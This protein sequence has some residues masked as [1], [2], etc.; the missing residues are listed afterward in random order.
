MLLTRL[1]E[2]AREDPTVPVPFYAPKAVR[3]VIELHPDGSL[4]S[5]QLTGLADQSNRD[6]RNGVV[7]LVPSVQ[8]SGTAA[9]PMLA[10]D[11]AEYVLGWATDEA[12][13]AKAVQYRAAFR[14]LTRRWYEAEK[15]PEAEALLAFLE[16]PHVAALARPEDLA[17]NHLVAVRVAGVFAHETDSAE[18]FWAAEAGS[19]KGSDRTG[20]CLVCGQAGPLLQTIPQQVPA[21]LV[22]GATNSA[23]LVSLNKPVHGFALEPQLVHTPIC[24][25]CGLSAMSALEAVLRGESAVTLPG[26]DSRLAWWVTGGAAFSL[27]ALDDPS[28][29]NVADLLGSVAT[30]RKPGEV[31]MSF[32]CALTVGGNVARIMVRDW[33]EL[34]LIEIQENIGRWFAEHQIADSWT[35]QPRYLPFRRLVNATGRWIPGRGKS[36]GTYAKF[37]APGADRPDGMERALWLAALLGKP[38]PPA[39]LA[40]VVHRIRTDGRLDTERAALVR[41]ALRRR[42]GLAD[43]E[44]YMPVL[45]PE[46]HRPSYLAGRL[47]A[48]LEDLQRSAGRARGDQDLNVTF[49]DRYY[50]RAITSPAVALV[51]GERDSRA[52]LKRLRRDRPAW[53]HTYE[54]QLDELYDELARAGGVPHGAVLPDQAAFILGYHQQH[55]ATRAARAAASSDKTPNAID[56]GDP[57]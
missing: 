3:W 40:H 9:Q 56:E 32:F 13:K 37:G 6:T 31:D 52:W 26:Q 53:A 1:V 11:T 50:A 57:A 23:S 24:V 12:R 16:A 47:F 27:D 33:I 29:Q 55:A 45:N 49:A 44:E 36:S 48:V 41:L 38:L 4:A 51:A 35:G 34:P 2:R 43:Q 8:R 18:R 42:P 7:R 5:N 21:R 22:P 17:G 20:V 30:G 39:L 46:N 25:N 10:V 19:R 28:P 15:S 14:D 54:K